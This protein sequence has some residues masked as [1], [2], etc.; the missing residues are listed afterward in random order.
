MFTKDAEEVEEAV[1]DV[2]DWLRCREVH[3]D[4]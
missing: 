3:Q 2:F 4:E 1:G